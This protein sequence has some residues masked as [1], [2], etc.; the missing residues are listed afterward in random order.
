MEEK[1]TASEQLAI[2]LMVA[3]GGAVILW[4]GFSLPGNS[5]Y[6]PVTVGAALIVL[7]LIS[8]FHV[9]G[10]AAAITDEASL[11][12]GL[13]GLALLVVFIWSAGS[14][15]FLTSSLWFIPVMA[16]LGGERHWLRA[17]LITFGFCLVAWLMFGLI[18]SQTM[19]P[20]LIFGEVG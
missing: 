17:L 3:A 15:G 18:F 1:V 14:I 8:A 12:R 2:N 11:P 19:P 7:S 10:K 4:D 9:I 5:A 13:A 6:F 20:E 16:V